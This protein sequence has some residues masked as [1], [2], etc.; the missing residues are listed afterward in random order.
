MHRSTTLQSQDGIRFNQIETEQR[1]RLFW[2]LYF[3]DSI[4]SF[5]LGRPPAIVDSDV[6]IELPESIEDSRIT[7]EVI[8]PEEME[9]QAEVYLYEPLQ[10]LSRQLRNIQRE[11]YS[12][13]RWKGR[14]QSDLLNTIYDVDNELQEWRAN[15][16]IEYRPFTS[17]EPS[18]NYAGASATKVFFTLA[19]YLCQ[20]VVHHP[21]LLEWIA[22]SSQDFPEE[23]GSQRRPGRQ[24]QVTQYVNPREHLVS[25]VADDFERWADRCIISARD[26]LNL[27]NSTAIAQFSYYHCSTNL[28]VFR[29]L[30]PFVVTAGSVI[31]ENLIRDPFSSTAAQDL[32]LLQ[33]ARETVQQNP[34]D[35]TRQP[36]ITILSELERLANTASQGNI[37]A[38]SA[39]SAASVISEPPQIFQ[40]QA[41]PS[42]SWDPLSYMPHEDQFV[43]QPMEAYQPNFPLPASLSAPTFQS[44]T[45]M[46]QSY[47]LLNPPFA[48]Q[49][50]P[51][52][53]GGL[54]A[55]TQVRQEMRTA[56]PIIQRQPGLQHSPQRS[57]LTS[58][59][60][61]DSATDITQS[62]LP[63]APQ[64]QFDQSWPPTWDM[65]QPPPPPQPQPP[66]SPTRPPRGGHRRRQSR[67]RGFPH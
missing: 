52:D 19:Y 36:T 54:S 44:S 61:S 32:Q 58:H 42:G 59:W 28:T 26:M 7:A 35:P 62:T 14:L 5:I 48:Y 10:S 31:V 45:P 50:Q 55:V 53:T 24:A 30:T 38:A 33:N 12:P 37:P 3:L 18:Q 67:A 47:P 57:N 2:C 6:D 17:G 27:I 39:A 63:S 22:K 66:A 20:C 49:Y 8:L 9:A 40:P 41:T 65:P 56:P 43:A 21:A 15:L 4:L 60:R 23:G 29:I 1:R 34:E 13:E 16:H 25:P 51:P 11:I 64:P 46:P